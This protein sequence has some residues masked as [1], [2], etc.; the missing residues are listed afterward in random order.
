MIFFSK[1]ILKV[2]QH[3]LLIESLEKKLKVRNF[4]NSVE[5]MQAQSTSP[6]Y[7]CY[8]HRVFYILVYKTNITYVKYLFYFQNNQNVWSK[9]WLNTLK[10]SFIYIVTPFNKKKIKKIKHKKS[11]YFSLSKH[12][13]GFRNFSKIQSGH[14]QEILC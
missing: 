10:N 7:T 1:C 14:T 2:H 13:C 11:T 4:S 5:A 9:I 12:H 8:F 3:F 6:F